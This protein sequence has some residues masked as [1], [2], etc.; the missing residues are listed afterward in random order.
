MK[1]LY[2][3]LCGKN[4]NKQVMDNHYQC[5]STESHIHFPAIIKGRAI[6]KKHASVSHSRIRSGNVVSGTR[7]T[8]DMEVDTRTVEST[9][10]S[11]EA[12][13]TTTS[14][15]ID[16]PAAE[17]QFQLNPSVIEQGIYVFKA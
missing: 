15:Q 13:T 8:T 11:R 16:T 3:C 17:F 1:L 5:T 10:Q 2:Q 14:M 12:A 4:G 9:T 6:Q 7:Y